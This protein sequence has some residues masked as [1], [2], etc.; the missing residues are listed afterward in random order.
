MSIFYDR[1][2]QV[3]GSLKQQG[4]GQG[5]IVPR[6]DCFQGEYVA[7]CDERL[8]WLTGF[9]GSA[10][11]AIVLE[12]TAALFVDGRYTVQ[13]AQEVG[14]LAVLH[15]RDTARWL[16]QE[17][18]GLTILYDP[19]LHTVSD[20][21]RLRAQHPLWLPMMPNP[22]DVLWRDRPSRPLTPIVDHAIQYAGKAAE[23]K[24]AEVQ[25]ML[26]AA[27]IDALVVTAH[28]SICWLLNKR[29]KDFPM[30]P[31]MYAYAIV[32]H[33]GSIQI[34]CD[35]GKL[36]DG[37]LW[38]THPFEQFEEDVAALETVWMDTQQAPVALAH[39]RH[40]KQVLWK[41]DP[42]VLGRA[43]KNTVEQDGARAAH[44]RDGVALTKFLAWAD[45]ILDHEEVV[46]EHMISEVLF[47]YRARSPLFQEPSFATIAGFGAN[48]AIVHYH[49]SSETAAS[50]EGEGLLLVDSGGQYLDG[51]TDVTRTI[52]IGQPTVEHQRYF[53]HVLKG[54]IALA[55]AI[56]PSGTTGGQLD[57]LARAPLWQIGV[58]YDHGT[59]H[60]VGSYLNVH[61]G[62]QRIGKAGATVSLQPGMI[63]SNEP[64]YYAQGEFGIRIENLML[65]VPKNN[66]FLGFETLTCAPLDTRLI[67]VS[68]LT[69]HEREW[70]NAYHLFVYETLFPHLDPDTAAWLTEQTQPL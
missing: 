34:Y 29:A 36:A 25:E 4:T 24:I 45:H 33:T 58:D 51:T 9:S 15:M 19:W 11:Y 64:G 57:V 5:L 60:G 50:I 67:D 8:K 69:N 38:V 12:H 39:C 23:D 14:A 20:L 21:E 31:S 48:G 35:Q 32:P 7:P 18:A 37:N 41:A 43:I 63:L 2:Q 55:T 22:I 47:Q 53:T 56:F 59:G 52:A 54:H 3:R 27:Q 46:D 13:A 1:L 28:E 49:A 26:K 6:A 62:P 30:L 40:G 68:L 66:D 16:A 61:E 10:G 44:V 42:C 70:V 17:A 65:V